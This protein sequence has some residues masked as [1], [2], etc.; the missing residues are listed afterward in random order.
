MALAHHDDLVGDLHRL[1][2]VVRDEDGRHVHLVVE[3]PQPFAQLLAN[4]GVERPEGL[5]EEE[6]GRIDCERA[7]QPHPLPLAAGELRRI[8]LCEALELDELQQ[9]V[10][11]LLDLGLRPL[12]DL[13]AERRRCRRRSCA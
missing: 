8:A 12:A 6:H 10:H 4:G 2:L 7:G 11:P 9:L 3:A 1:L 5:V 13:E